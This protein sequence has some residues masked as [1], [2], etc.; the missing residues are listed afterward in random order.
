MIS[1]D[2]LGKEVIHDDANSIGKVTEMDFDVYKGTLNFFEG[3]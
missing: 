3:Q 2:F 1:R